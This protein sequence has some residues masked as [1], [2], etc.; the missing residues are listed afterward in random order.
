MKAHIWKRGLLVALSA[1]VA[2]AFTVNESLKS[3]LRW[4]VF[5]KSYKEQVS[6][7]PAPAD[8]SFKHIEWDGWGVPGAGK[9]VMY[10]V[11]DPANSLAVAAKLRSPGKGAG[12]PCGVAQVSRLKSQWYT[13]FFYTDT[14]WQ[15]YISNV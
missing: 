5:A 9:T 15:R 6:A 14:K 1:G 12:L 2:L 10:L 7:L 13:V 8:G 11:F 3:G 4:A